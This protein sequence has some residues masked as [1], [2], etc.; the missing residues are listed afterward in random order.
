MKHL[1]ADRKERR[2]AL[3][4]LVITAALLITAVL[5]P[6]IYKA[7][8]RAE[9][10]EKLALAESPTEKE[11][12]NKPDE[13]LKAEK[14]V[15]FLARDLRANT[16][17]TV[18]LDKHYVLVSSTTNK[19]YFVSE[20]P[21]MSVSNLVLSALKDQKDLKVKPADVVMLQSGTAI[22]LSSGDWIQDGGELIYTVFL[23]AMGI[24]M[25]RQF[26][27]GDSKKIV[28]D[29]GVRFKDVIGAAEAKEA[30]KDI[31][32]Y[33]KDP[34]RYAAVGARPS[35]GV[36]ALG[37]PGTGKTLLAKAVAGECGVPFI[38]INGSSF[39]SSFVGAGISKI[40]Q[41]FK[42]ARKHAP[43]ILFI[44]EI[45][46]LGKRSSHGDAV[47]TEN[48]RMLNQILVEM[49]GFKTADGIIVIAATNLLDNVDEA[50]VR[51]GRFDRKIYVHL[52]TVTERTELFEYY[53]GKV[54]LDSDVDFAQL[55]RVTTGMSPSSIES[56]VNQAALIAVGASRPTVSHADIIEAIEVS[57]MGKARSET[58]FMTP[59]L[60]ELT[61]YHEAGH[62]VIAQALGVG[63]VEK[64]TIIPRG[65]ALGVTLVTQDDEPLRGEKKLSSMIEMLFG[66]RCAEVLVYGEAST[67]AS[68]D[69]KRASEIALS[70]VAKL[71][72]GGQRKFFNI[73]AL[74]NPILASGEMTESVARANRLLDQLEARCAE[75]L[76]KYREALEEVT[77]ALLEHET[78]DGSVVAAAVARVDEANALPA[79]EVAAPEAAP[80]VASGS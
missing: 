41:V 18:G 63:R 1:P 25:M 72:M 67:G 39:S 68:S 32:D 4:V 8:K 38:A 33:L 47:T 48:N 60:R 13:W 57:Q 75:R 23:L 53:G 16:V 44:D 2:K 79:T 17:T 58:S 71:G 7:W 62:A 73:D 36:L 21:S 14:D 30:M 27:I 6:V 12:R 64:V 24:S 70:M 20:S 42:T 35:A 55:G 52:P 3:V 78:I 45:D 28:K 49:D 46:G 29:T 43:C 74:D 37:A 22:A 26:G 31:V 56:V 66:G 19:Q 50:L 11:M 9:A 59:E 10:R 65:G 80:E 15:S 54:K 76:E 51:E 40:R 34:K 5:S 61:A 77:A 69:L